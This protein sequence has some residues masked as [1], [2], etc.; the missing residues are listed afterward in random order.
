MFLFYSLNFLIYYSY[1]NKYYIQFFLI[2]L[3]S[4]NYYSDNYFIKTDQLLED[5]LNEL[6]YFELIYFYHGSFL[7]SFDYLI[8]I[9]IYSILICDLISDINDTKATQLK[10]LLDI[11]NI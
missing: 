10:H 1:F 6:N 8:Q 9:F 3:T 11:I 2:Y 4:N 5:Y 7:F